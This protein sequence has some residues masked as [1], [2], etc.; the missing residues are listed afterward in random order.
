MSTIGDVLSGNAQW[1]VLEADCS[2]VLP[3]LPGRCVDHTLTDPPYASEIYERCR[4]N[5]AR[6]DGGVSRGLLEMSRGRIGTLE[7]SLAVAPDIARVTRRWAM[8]WSDE[9]ST[10]LWRA[11]LVGHGMRYMRCGAWVKNNPMPQ[12]SGDRPAMGFEAAVI[13]H[14]DGKAR[15]NGGGSAAVWHHNV[16]GG[17]ERDTPHPCPKPRSLMMEIVELFTDPGELVLDP[18]CGSGSLGIACVRLGRRYLGMDNGKDSNGKPWAQWAREGIE[19]ESRG[20]SRS[21]YRA[22]QLGLF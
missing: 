13:C 5:P 8:I 6:H 11:L 7:G 18:F 10:H 17:V 19:A 4:K 15:W 14:A 9:E 2:E 20:M 12:F 3:M 22:G 16:C 1:C 21:A